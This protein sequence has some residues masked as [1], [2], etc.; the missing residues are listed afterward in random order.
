LPAY[1]PTGRVWFSEDFFVVLD[2][3][4]PPC[5]SE[6]DADRELAALA[7][8]HDAYFGRGADPAPGIV[9]PAYPLTIAEVAAV[10]RLARQTVYELV[11]D[12]RLSSFRAGRAIRITRAA[13]DAFM[14]GQA[15]RSHP[16]LD[17]VPEGPAHPVPQPRRK[18]EPQFRH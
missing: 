6:A 5:L 15:P 3:P 1:I 17:P 4:L 7:A 12:G 11:A 8:L 16:V 18:R 13:L 2:P 9:G 14:A 10:L